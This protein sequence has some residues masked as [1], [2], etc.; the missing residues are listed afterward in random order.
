MKLEVINI[1][2]H[3]NY[4]VHKIETG[5]LLVRWNSVCVNNDE[6]RLHNV[7]LSFQRFRFLKYK[8]CHILLERCK[9]CALKFKKSSNVKPCN[10]LSFLPSSRNS[11][12]NRVG[13]K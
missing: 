3:A 5:V 9:L 7:K 8:G 11:F 10:M 4:T 12:P 2:R 13:M 1:H 6:N